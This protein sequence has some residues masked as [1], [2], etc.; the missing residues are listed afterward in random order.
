MAK[1]KRLLS[2]ENINVEEVDYTFRPKDLTDFVGQKKLKDNLRVFIKA[3][4]NRKESLDHILLHGPPGLGKTTLAHIIA[5][6]MGVNLK[7][8]QAPVLEK[9]G[10]IAAHLTNLKEFDVFF[11]DEIHR[12]KSAIEEI[13]YSAMEDFKIDIVIGQGAGAK[14]VKIDL[15]RFTLIG[16]TTKAGLLTPPFYARFGIVNRLDL[17]DETLL[18]D[19][20]YRTASM[21]NIDID[22]D[23]VKEIARRSRGTPRVLNRIMRRIRDF[24]QVE[25][26]G[27]ITLYIAKDAL[28]K[29]DIDDNGLDTMDRRLLMT[30]MENYSGGPVGLDTLAVSLGETADTI[31]D[32]YEPFLIQK[33]FIARTPRG[34]ITTPLC[35]NYFGLSKD[36]DFLL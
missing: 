22:D 35:Y 34:R 26:N 33:G 18:R 7:A 30:I 11:I 19:I 9:T 25:G 5:N 27:K 14:I 4:R 15:P 13:L 10:D 12:V 24:A 28:S 31:E 29:L 23:S 20:A 21:M 36:G 17:Y 32:V 8:V 2:T 6:E 1:E 3:A 16:A